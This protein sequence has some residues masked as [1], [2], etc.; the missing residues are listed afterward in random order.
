MLNMKSRIDSKVSGHM[1][2]GLVLLLFLIF[3]VIF[4]I[5]QRS[6]A[7]K[8]RMVTILMGLFGIIVLWYISTRQ[9][10]GEALLAFFA[11]LILNLLFWLLIGR[12]NPVGSSDSIRVLGMDD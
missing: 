12:Y 9:I 11:A 1:Q 3:V 6:E 5:I 2:G 10:W 7:K 8:R 4:M